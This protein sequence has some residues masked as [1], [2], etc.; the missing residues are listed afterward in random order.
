MVAGKPGTAT[1]RNKEFKKRID[2]RK[3][4]LESLESYKKSLFPSKY[5]IKEENKIILIPE[6]TGPVKV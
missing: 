5:N 3:Q 6:I 1:G 4:V 2:S